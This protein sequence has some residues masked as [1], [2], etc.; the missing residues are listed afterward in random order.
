MKIYTKTGD[1]GETG[2]VGSK[3]ISKASA[4][5][6]AIGSVDELNSL[7][8]V[9]RSEPLDDD[10]ES[11]LQTIQNDLFDLG[12][13][14]ASTPEQ[15]KKYSIAPI[16]ENRI[17]DL[18]AQIDQ[19]Q[20]TIPEIRQFILPAGNRAASLTHLARSVC[21]RA[22][23]AVIYLQ[24]ESSETQIPPTVVAFLNRLS[25][26]LFIVARCLNHRG[27]QSETFWKKQRH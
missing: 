9:I 26:W 7:I 24:G 12:A 15:Q 13:I 5:I 6:D 10:F 3:R 1:G 4:R 20:K 21:R 25:D 16:S 27:G 2:L 18:E 19:L 11:W 8:G 22:E 17:Q 14:L 23:R